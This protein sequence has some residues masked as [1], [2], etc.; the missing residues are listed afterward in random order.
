MNGFLVFGSCGM[1]DIL[2]AAFGSRSSA[3]RFAKKVKSHDIIRVAFDVYKRDVSVVL[4][5]D[6]VRFRDG[7]PA[8]WER[9]ADLD[10]GQLKLDPHSAQD[11]RD[12]VEGKGPLAEQWKDKPHRLVYDLCRAVDGKAV[13]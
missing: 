7:R 1:D 3:V 5:V 8:A 4:G 6:V 11:Y 13:Q 10:H 12:A 9:V 2:L